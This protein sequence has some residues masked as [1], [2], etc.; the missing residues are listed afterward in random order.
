MFV[1]ISLLFSLVAVCLVPVDVT[2]AETDSP[3][4]YQVKAAFLYKL[5]LYVEWPESAFETAE[6]PVS[7]GVLGPR[8]MRNQVEAAVRGRSLA[9]RSVTVTHAA[10]QDLSNFHVLFVVRSE[11]RRLDR[12]LV[13]G[14]PPVLV[15]TESPDWQEL[16]SVINFVLTEDR[17]RFDVDLA[18]AEKRGLSLSSQ[19][20]NVA[21]NVRGKP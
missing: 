18:A 19:L 21:R 4:E 3:L 13:S 10:E 5:A 9:S 11:E 15:V 1:R 6:S 2:Q 16:G 17:I 12:R 20:L 8:W 14:D 7:V